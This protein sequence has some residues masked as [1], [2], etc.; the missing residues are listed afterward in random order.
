MNPK[1]I[2]FSLLGAGVVGGVTTGGYFFMTPS[3]IKELL[4]SEGTKLLDVDG[5]KNDKEWKILVDKHNQDKPTIKPNI[6]IPKIGTLKIDG[7]DDNAKIKQLKDKCKELFKKPITE[8][9]KF[10][11][12]AKNWCTLKSPLLEEAKP[13]SADGGVEG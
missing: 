2:L 8:K 9:E 10:K 12:P 7:E 13:N 11:D 1:T 3:T 4:I 5:N 6:E